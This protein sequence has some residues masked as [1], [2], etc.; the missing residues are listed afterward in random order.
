MS[1]RDAAQAEILVWALCDVREKMISQMEWLEKHDRH[2]DAAALRRDIDEAES[3]ITR[4]RRRY[5]GGEI[6]APL[7]A[8]Q[9]SYGPP[10]HRVAAIQPGR[11]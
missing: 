2:R 8:R 10:K 11:V 3:L 1:Q 6:R 5:L 7:P 4:L 9:P